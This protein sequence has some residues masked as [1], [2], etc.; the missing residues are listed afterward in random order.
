MKKKI[1]MSLTLIE[2]WLRE[3]FKKGELVE[4]RSTDSV[5]IISRSKFTKNDL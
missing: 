4:L 1:D 3:N 5:L 2:K